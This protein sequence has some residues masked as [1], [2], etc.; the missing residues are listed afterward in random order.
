MATDAP[1]Q[2][3]P[4]KSAPTPKSFEYVVLVDGD[5]A[6]Q[7]DVV[8]APTDVDTPI[9]FKTTARNWEARRED[10]IGQVLKRDEDLR[11]EL[12]GGA[13]VKFVLIPSGSWDP[14]SVEL[15]PRDPELKIS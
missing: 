3:K 14:K 7:W 8:A 11:N 13:K 10:I 15:E 12:T 1:V 4:A 5:S 9:V 2:P 6:G